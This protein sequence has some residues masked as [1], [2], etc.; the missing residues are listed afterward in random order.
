MKRGETALIRSIGHSTVVV[1]RCKRKVRRRAAGGR[2]GGVGEA[3][4]R[5]R[6]GS[7]R[8]RG[9]SKVA[10]RP[11]RRLRKVAVRASKRRFFLAIE[12]S[13]PYSETSFGVNEKFFRRAATPV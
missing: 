6:E 10:R 9:G 5:C 3:R 4:P 1:S 7:R 12:K 11:E 8:C 2:V 13:G